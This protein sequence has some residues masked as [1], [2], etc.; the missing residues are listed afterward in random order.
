MP[1]PRSWNSADMI[2]ES[3]RQPFAATAV[4]FLWDT[5]PAVGHA[6][7]SCSRSCKITH[8]SACQLIDAGT[9]ML[10]EQQD[11]HSRD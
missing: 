10:P 11:V 4:L 5:F 7:I 9:S 2:S 8:Q 1:P 3:Q 6:K